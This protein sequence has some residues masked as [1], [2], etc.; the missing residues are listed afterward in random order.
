MSGGSSG[1]FRLAVTCVQQP[2]RRPE[3][4]DPKPDPV[5]RQTREE[6]PFLPLRFPAAFPAES[7]AFSGGFSD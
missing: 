6:D 2:R 5:T 1:G 7:V 3:A 4:F